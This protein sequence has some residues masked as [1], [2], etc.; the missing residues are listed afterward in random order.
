MDKRD[1][2]SVGCLLT[3]SLLMAACEQQTAEQFRQKQHLPDADFVA[4]AEQGKQLFRQHCARCHG[5][6]GKG[7][8]LGPP[9]V[10]EVYRPGHHH[11]LSFH[12]AVKDGV[13]QHHWKFGNMPPIPAVS[14]QQAEHIIAY[15]RHEQIE[16]GI[17]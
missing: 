8:N 6:T 2:I 9:L 3:L 5:E 1:A 12:W 7:M 4:D 10:H 16:A 13:K 11:D 17:R 14:P 15:V